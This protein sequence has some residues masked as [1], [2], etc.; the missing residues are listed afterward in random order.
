MWVAL[1]SRFNDSMVTLVMMFRQT[2]GSSVWGVFRNEAKCL[3]ACEPI[4]LGE[5]RWWGGG[6]AVAS[7]HLWVVMKELDSQAHH[8][9]GLQFEAIRSWI[10][11]L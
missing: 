7:R 9:A 8:A 1:R 2:R 3:T 10:G 4:S 5:A 6:G 11:L